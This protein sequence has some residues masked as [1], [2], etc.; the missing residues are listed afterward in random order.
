MS[1]VV[2]IQRIFA[3]YR[4]DILDELHRKI[5]FVLLH[6]VNNSGI[7]QVST[8]YS[9]KVKSFKYSHNNTN[10]FL[11]VFPHLLRKRPKIVI[12][13][14]SIGIAS[15]I[16]TYLLTRLLGIKFILWGHGYDR[17]KGFYPEKSIN[18][19]LR[20]LFLKKADA[21][22]FYGQEA[23]LEFSKYLRVEK[24]FV[25]HNCLNTNVLNIIRKELE[26]EGTENVK[27][28]IGF[29]HKY[30]II[31][32]GRLLKYKQPQMLFDVYDSLTKTNDNSI[33]IH[34]VG[35]GEF[36]IQLK[37][38]AKTRGIE[39]NVK[40]YGAIYDDVKNGELLYCSD[41]MIM[42]GP[43]G[44]SVNHA[45]NF[46]C[47]V[48]SFKQKGHGP[49]IEYLINEKTGFVIE[50]P[51]IDAMVSTIGRYINNEE[52]QQQMKLNIRNMIETTCSIESFIK[53]FEDANKFVLL[54]NSSKNVRDS[55]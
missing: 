30:N 45:F 49:E 3:K 5:D 15:I 12:H 28:R 47:P 22:I 40:F 29:T 34:F 42:P 10:V 41:L 46:D 24:L 26:T 23:K 14:F 6:S 13:E 44:L 18:D 50:T 53:G 37:E 32:I 20:L 19:K 48:V 1:D 31:Y 38:I 9:E 36:L 54:N 7:S 39:E 2:I 21:V 4:K 43:V 27:R 33:C 11:N 8:P 17:S 52:L 16:P 51:T 35:D 25:A 55:I